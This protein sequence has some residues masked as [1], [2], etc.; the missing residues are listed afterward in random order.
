MIP[1]HRVISVTATFLF[2]FGVIMITGPSFEAG[3]V[4]HWIWGQR[5]SQ[6][7]LLC[8]LL[9]FTAQ[10]IE[11]PLSKVN[12]LQRVE[13]GQC[14]I[15]LYFELQMLQKVINRFWAPN[16]AVSSQTPGKC[17]FVLWTSPNSPPFLPFS[18][19]SSLFTELPSYLLPII[20]FSLMPRSS[21]LRLP[22]RTTESNN[23]RQRR[24]DSER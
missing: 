10:E 11:A 18:L 16:V 20:S 21:S 13:I 19:L 8:A 9:L 15:N 12:Q 6:P 14:K 24:Q 22:G 4:V 5:P 17:L 3:Y 1:D 2:I 23:S 7:R